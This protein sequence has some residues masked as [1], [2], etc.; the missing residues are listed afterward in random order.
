MR[1]LALAALVALAACTTPGLTAVCKTGPGLQDC[2][3]LP[4]ELH[5]D[6]VPHDFPSPQAP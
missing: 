1:W 5:V 3:V 6:H 4:D 2:W